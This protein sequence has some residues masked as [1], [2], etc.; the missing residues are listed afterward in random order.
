MHPE[1]INTREVKRYF[2]ENEWLFWEFVFFDSC[3]KKHILSGNLVSLLFI[4]QKVVINWNNLTNKVIFKTSEVFFPRI[5]PA[6]SDRIRGKQKSTCTSTNAYYVWKRPQFVPLPQFPSIT[7]EK[8]ENEGFAVKKHQVFSVRT[9]PEFKTERF[10]F[11][12]TK[13]GKSTK[14]PAFSNAFRL[15]ENEKLA[16]S[17]FSGLKTAF[18]GKAPFPWQISVDGRSNRINKTAFLNSA[19]EVWTHPQQK[20]SLC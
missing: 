12:Q 4:F 8:F 17:N 5:V 11:E 14:V 13:L 10:V 3:F 6:R 2:Q 18:A 16:F 19:G 7:P 1:G 9:T 20:W 15:H